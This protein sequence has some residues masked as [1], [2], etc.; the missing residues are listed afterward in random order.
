MVAI[1]LFKVGGLLLRTLTKPVAKQLKQS[2]K[3]KPWLNSV[4]RSVGQHQHAIGVRIQMSMQGQIHW[5]T[6]QIKELP[7]DQ[8]VDKGSE[9]LGETLIFSVAVIVA[10]YEYDRSSRSAKAKELKANEREFQRLQQ[11][12]M[13]FRNLEHLM[14]SMQDEISVLKQQVDDATAKLTLY[15]HEQAE[16]A[17]QQQHQ[18]AA[19]GRW[20]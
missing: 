10:W 20:W 4:C 5:K 9:F 2:A 7:A 8:A 15:K 3:T 6:I 11:I 17:R 19:T 18:V 1:P 13:R 14:A 16:V 12:E